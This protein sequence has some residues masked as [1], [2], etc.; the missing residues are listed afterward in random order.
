MFEE[1]IGKNMEVCIDNM[2]VKSLK[3]GD[4]INNLRDTFDILEKYYMKL[5]PVKCTFGIS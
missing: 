3:S 2:L 5:N 4:H 1:K